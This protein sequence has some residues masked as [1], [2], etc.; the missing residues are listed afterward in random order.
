L[1]SVFSIIVAIITAI[2]KVKAFW[3]QLLAFYVQ[4]K[5]D[6]FKEADRAA[7]RKAIREHDQRDLEKQIG[8]RRP[9][10]PSRLPGT[11]I[12]NHN[13]IPDGVLQNST[14][15]RN[16]SNNLDEQRPYDPFIMP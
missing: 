7:I 16:P 4:S 11:D 14:K 10:E 12:V 8:N 5:I 13:V 9:G 1:G 15:G 2:P 6:D 3:D